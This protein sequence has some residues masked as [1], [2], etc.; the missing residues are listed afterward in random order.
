MKVN[1]AEKSL[2][3]LPLLYSKYMNMLDILTF[4]NFIFY[5]NILFA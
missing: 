3:F 2:I 1:F 4:Y 5:Y